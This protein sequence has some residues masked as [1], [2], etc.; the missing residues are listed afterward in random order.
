[1]IKATGTPLN[2][3]ALKI[4]ADAVA[5]G[6]YEKP[7]ETGTMLMLVVSELSEALE[8]D[9]TDRHA[10]GDFSYG[11]ATLE[12]RENV[13]DTFEDEIADSVI[14]LLDLCGHLDIDIDRHI[15]AKM[16]YNQT[17]PIRHNKN[18]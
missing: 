13:K 1:M 18:Y 15:K 17:R 12:F 14:R 16:E 2:A 11:G 5:K 3:L 8:A 7:R 9:R 10:P 4:H 6:F